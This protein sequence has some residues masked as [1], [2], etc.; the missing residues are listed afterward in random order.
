MSSEGLA[1]LLLRPGDGL[2]WLPHS[3]GPLLQGA[4]AVYGHTESFL[5]DRYCC[6]RCFVTMVMVGEQGGG[7]TADQVAL[8]LLLLVLWLERA[9]KIT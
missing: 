4:A 5:I 6:W 1:T 3:L 9:C 7:C 8:L 2:P